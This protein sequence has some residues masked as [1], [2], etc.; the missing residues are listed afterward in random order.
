MDEVTWKWKAPLYNQCR[1]ESMLTVDLKEWPI[2]GLVRKD[3]AVCKNFSNHW[4]ILSAQ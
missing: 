3:F 2:A 4:R 1:P